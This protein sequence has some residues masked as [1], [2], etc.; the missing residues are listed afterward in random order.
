MNDEISI[1]HGN[2][3][4]AVV[5]LL[6]GVYKRS[7]Y[8]R[9]ILP[10]TV[11]RRLDCVLKHSR[12]DVPATATHRV[13]CKDTGSPVSNWSTVQS[14]SNTSQHSFASLVARP[15]NL[16]RDLREYIGGFPPFARDIIEKFSFDTQIT[17]LAA[18]N[19][20]YLVT[21]QIADLDLNPNVVSNVD[22]GN[23][24]EKLIMQFSDETTGEHFTP[25]D[26]IR[27]MVS[28]LFVEDQD[29]LAERGTTKTMLDPAC[30]T[31][32]MLFVSQEHLR[33]L[34]PGARMEVYGQELNGET[35]ATCQAHMLVTGQDCSR[36]RM[37]NSFDNDQHSSQRFDYLLTNPPFG[38]RW[39]TVADTVRSEYQT[40]GY[41]GR[42]GAG[43]PPLN[44]SSFLFL[45]HMIS[46]MKRP[47]EGVAR[48][49]ILFDRTSMSIGSA[50]TGASEIRRW[51][52][53]NDW[54]EAVV[55][56]PDELFYNTE[57]TT[58]LWV[59]TNRKS[60]KRCG[61]VQLIDVR[62]SCSEAPKVLGMKRKRFSE[63]QIIEIA[64]LYPALEDGPRSKVVSNADIGVRFGY[65]VP[66]TRYFP[67]RSPV[68]YLTTDK[69]ERL[70]TGHEE[71][72]RQRTYPIADL[73]GPDRESLNLEY[74]STLLWDIKQQ[75][76]S[77]NIEDATIKTIAGFANS[78]YGGTLLIGVTDTGAIHGLEDDY[79]T[80]SKRGQ[81]GDRDLWGQHLQNLIRHRLGDAA[82]ALINWEFHKTNGD[83]LAR[84][85]IEPSDYPIYDHKGKTETFWHRT[86][87]STISITDLKE[88]NRI[89][90]HRWSREAP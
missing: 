59:L 31:G 69:Q 68:G 13:D 12:S 49:G 25:R 47:E 18:H 58:Y 22:M 51:I 63:E 21:A 26:V 4:S 9:V 83:D 8:W 87:V 89:I 3:F 71:V 42:F 28:L 11:L 6:R 81:R 60:R 57:I 27:L 5:D 80:F 85:N 74:K 82:L 90:S 15:E 1:N 14:L 67:S 33:D 65:E 32:G 7:E 24:F 56:L 30:G 53:E 78:P 86:P 20:L 43:L 77:R 55:A 79:A 76:K 36:I 75:Q 10:F 66:F 50:D 64:R 62:G 44:D 16:A 41:E 52:V 34:N 54:L 72:A 45:Q 17:R 70:I 88:R 23:T 73:L 40:K 2:V 29:A 35:F 39:E 61:R 37:G 19:L 46:K 84:I 38:L 48:L